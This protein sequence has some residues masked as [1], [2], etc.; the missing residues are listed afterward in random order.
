MTLT[1]C[2]AAL[3]LGL[4][5][6]QAGTPGALASP[7]HRFQVSFPSAPT[8]S[9]VPLQSGG[10]TVDRWRWEGDGVLLF[11]DVS[12]A[13][14]GKDVDPATALEAGVAYLKTRAKINT[15][16]PVTVDGVTGR[17][18]SGTMGGG[19]IS[20][21]YFVRDGKLY[22][23]YGATEVTATDQQ[24]EVKKRLARVTAYMD[25]FHFAR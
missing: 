21:R 13:T 6:V 18:L 14:G 12:P 11:L 4:L 10:G 23:V 22:Q 16:E 19:F 20:G 7:A 3:M 25:T 1:L 17:A 8:A 2:G 5:P 9:S 24:A 15:E